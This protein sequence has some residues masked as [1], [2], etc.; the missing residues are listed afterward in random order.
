MKKSLSALL[1]LI[2]ISYSNA[3][4]IYRYQSSEQIS[5][6]G[7]QGS[8]DERIDDCSKKRNKNRKNFSLVARFKKDSQE[9]YKELS[10][11]LLW[12]YRLS[13]A[14]DQYNAEKVCLEDFQDQAGIESVSWRLPSIHEYRKAEESNIRD[15]PDMHY[16]FWS[17][18]GYELYNSSLNA[19][20]F[21]GD[22]GRNEGFGRHREVA[23]RCVAEVE[24]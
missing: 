1:V 3:E 8:I 20:Q 24:K 2:S 6:C 19:W 5:S 21:N 22:N 4:E 12:S 10:T 17:S 7:L 11:G 9:I 16:W 15:L 18:S 23:V 13:N 14:M